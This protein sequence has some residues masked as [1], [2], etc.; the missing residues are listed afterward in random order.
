MALYAIADPH[1]SFGVGKPMDIFGP[2]WTDHAAKLEKNWRAVV[3]ADDTVV[4]PG[5]ISWAMTLEDAREDF[6]FLDELPG[7]KILA[8]GNHDYWWCTLSRMNAFLDA[9]SFRSIRFLH[10]NAYLADGYA[11][12]GT[13]GWF[14]EEQLQKEQEGAD[15]H[16][17][18]A[19]EAGRL[20]TSIAAAEKLKSE[21]RCEVPTL[22]YLHFPP[23]FRTF[24]CRELIDVLHEFSIRDVYYGHIHGAYDIPRCFDFE[25]IRMTVIAADHLFFTPLRTMPEKNGY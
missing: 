2:R 7:V 16:K 9:N 25:G 6:A 23:V 8:K 12:C 15:W 20:R 11:V 5:D 17:L 19:R 18:V 4:L 1:L 21:S 22:V 10:N 3:G 13:R 24:V 14:V